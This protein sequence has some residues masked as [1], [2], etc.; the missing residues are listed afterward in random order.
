MSMTVCS[1][2]Y[3]IGLWWS[4]G[5]SQIQLCWF[6]GQLSV[7]YGVYFLFRTVPTP[8]IYLW[9]KKKKDIASSQTLAETLGLTFGSVF[10]EKHKTT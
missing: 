10:H 4:Q 8:H 5:P 1:L 7:I 2:P 9:E 3:K 6:L